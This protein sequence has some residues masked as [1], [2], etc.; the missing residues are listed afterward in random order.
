MNANSTVL[1]IDDERAFCDVVAE[2]LSNS[3]YEVEK[4]YDVDQAL[5]ILQNIR[6]DLILVDIMMPGVD[7]LSLTRQLRCD[8]CHAET[9]IIVASAKSTPEDYDH[10]IQSGANDFLLKPFSASTLRNMI[11]TYLTQ[12]HPTS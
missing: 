9:P 4:A 5:S 12:P 1:V 6:P 3:G 8:P 7:G 2:I 11:D 10:A